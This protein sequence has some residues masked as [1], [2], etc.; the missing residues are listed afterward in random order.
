MEC[1]SFRQEPTGTVYSQLV[2]FCVTLADRFLLVERDPECPAD[3]RL[4]GILD[5]LR[6]HLLETRLAKEW[7]GTRLLADEARLY[8]F[9]ADSSLAGKLCALQP[10]LFD[11]VHPSAPEDPCF[12]RPDGE[13]LLITIS[14]ERDAYLVLTDS[15]RTELDLKF[16]LLAA[17]LEHEGRA[18]SLSS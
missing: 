6:P 13:A 2:L 3:D 18:E 16:S 5:D 12:L 17:T 8:W 14:H 1:Y 4:S 9:R 10:G 15:E 11:W 7:P